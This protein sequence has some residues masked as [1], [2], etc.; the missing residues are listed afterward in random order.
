MKLPEQDKTTVIEF[1]VKILK[2]FTNV[3]NLAYL[4]VDLNALI[5]AFYFI[6]FN[7]LK[8]KRLQV[9]YRRF[10][11]KYQDALILR[12]VEK[13]SFIL[14]LTSSLLISAIIMFVEKTVNRDIIQ[15]QIPEKYRKQLE[16]IIINTINS[17][18]NQSMEN[19]IKL[20][21]ENLKNNNMLNASELMYDDKGI[22]ILA[23]SI[24]RLG[25]SL[26][27]NA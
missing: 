17:T 13:G 6:S 8:A 25:K 4:L 27:V 18:L 15:I 21:Y 1:S 11:D 19:K 20:L 16:P 23:N 5:N 7:K 9:T 22:K 24:I 12:S 3:F 26:N 14:E 10:A 2:R